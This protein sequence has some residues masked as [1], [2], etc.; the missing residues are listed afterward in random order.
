MKDML[1]MITIVVIS[2]FIIAGGVTYATEDGRQRDFIQTMT[3]SIQATAIQ[4][5]DY[6][7]RVDRGNIFI[8]ED[9]FEENFKR[10]FNNN[11]NVN[12]DSY[13]FDFEYLKD[14]NG[15]KAIRVVLTDDRGT[16]YPAT[17]AIDVNQD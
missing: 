14:E 12:I 9:V 17:V 7:S 11:R 8:D 4:S 16:R 6:S 10:N 1:A 5:F 13:T 3:E 2:F 15:T